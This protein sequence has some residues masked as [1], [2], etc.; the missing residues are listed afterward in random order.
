MKITNRLSIGCVV[1]NC[2]LLVALLYGY[3][4]LFFLLLNAEQNEVDPN[5]LFNTLYSAQQ[6]MLLLLTATALLG[7]LTSFFSIY[8]LEKPLSWDD[9]SKSTLAV[10]PMILFFVLFL[11]VGPYQEVSRSL[12]L[13]NYDLEWA[14]MSIS[15]IKNFAIGQI[16]LWILLLGMFVFSYAKILRL[17]ESISS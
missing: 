10:F 14:V 13:V 2:G 3:C 8:V 11:Q 1:I 9:R 4:S 16:A 15:L 17:A 6:N 7:I 12:A 5:L